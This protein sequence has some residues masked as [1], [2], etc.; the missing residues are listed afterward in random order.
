MKEGELGAPSFKD[1]GSLAGRDT[2][3]CELVCACPTPVRT[4]AEV[5]NLDVQAWRLEFGMMRYRSLQRYDVVTYGMYT[6]IILYGACT[7][8][9]DSIIC[10]F[11]AF[12]DQWNLGLVEHP[13][14]PPPKT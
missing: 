2:G 14:A 11:F 13:T 3:G 9:E 5:I 8:H 1:S 4:I 7:G 12:V 6:E 10:V